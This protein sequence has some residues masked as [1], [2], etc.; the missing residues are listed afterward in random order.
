MEWGLFLSG[1]VTIWS[2]TKLSSQST[3]T[4]QS[5]KITG[6]N[7]YGA[8]GMYARRQLGH[9]TP[10][11]YAGTKGI[12]GPSFNDD[13]WH[14]LAMVVDGG[15]VTIYHKGAV[16]FEVDDP[17]PSGH[18]HDSATGSLR[19]GGSDIDTGGNALAWNM[20]N[21][22]AIYDLRKFDRPLTAEEVLE[23]SRC[24]ECVA[25]HLELQRK[26]EVLT[27]QCLF[28]AHASSTSSL[29]LQLTPD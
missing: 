14:H 29:A 23:I 11:R 18:L 3:V 22:G 6:V 20:V 15:K 4:E 24:I 28:P 9:D 16:L 27:W 5:A 7:R 19:L 1:G 13:Q 8:S 25:L 10:Y 26:A 21:D 17:D 2:R 12:V